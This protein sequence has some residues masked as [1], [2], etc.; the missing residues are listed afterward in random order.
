MKNPHGVEPTRLNVDPSGGIYCLP[1]V[2]PTFYDGHSNK[3]DMQ[4]LFTDVHTMEADLY[5]N[6]NCHVMNS[7]STK[8]NGK[9]GYKCHPTY[10]SSFFVNT[11]GPEKN[12]RFS[13]V[14]YEVYTY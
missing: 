14:D 9:I 1:A 2:G 10:K 6:N 7:C 11:A 12:N 5:I 3:N 8:N 13:V 4:L